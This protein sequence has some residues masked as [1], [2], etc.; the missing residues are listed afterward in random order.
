MSVLIPDFLQTP[1]MSG[2]FST[3]I[4]VLSDG[5]VTVSGLNAGSKASDS[6]IVY[7]KSELGTEYYP[8]FY[9]GTDP[10]S[11]FYQLQIVPLND[12]ATIQVTLRA[13]SAN[14]MVVVFQGLEY[15]SGDTINVTLNKL[16]MLQ[17]VST[18]DLSGTFVNSTSRVAVFSGCDYTHLAAT[19]AEIHYTKQ[20]PEVNRLG[21][22]YVL[23][24]TGFVNKVVYTSENTTVL[25]IG[26]DICYIYES[27]DAGD[28]FFTKGFSTE[29]VFVL[30]ANKPVVVGSFS[31][32][33][34]GHV[35]M[36]PIDQYS[37]KYDVPDPSIVNLN[38]TTWYRTIFDG[39]INTMFLNDAPVIRFVMPLFDIPGT[40][41]LYCANTT[42]QNN[43]YT[44]YESLTNT[45]FW[46]LAMVTYGQSE[47]WMS[48]GS[49]M[50][51]NVSD[52]YSVADLGGP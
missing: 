25:L 27:I 9:C 34:R 20:V 1:S 2:I 47:I 22:E 15:F 28:F 23:F 36:T 29:P 32:L 16:D 45:A 42:L 8:A 52:S 26:S 44:K 4:R 12:N 17:L 3:G 13:V 48:V 50:I 21:Y 43:N 14:G 40:S 51:V 41:L 19:G 38:V 49:A 46:A 24:G 6:F 39:V 10:A 5:D 18:V 31:K 35:Y 37:T 11:V 33:G 30:K 7:P